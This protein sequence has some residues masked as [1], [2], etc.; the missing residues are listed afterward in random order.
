MRLPISCCWLQSDFVF[1][2]LSL[3][4]IRATYMIRALLVYFLQSQ[5]SCAYRYW[6]ALSPF[7]FEKIIITFLPLIFQKHYLGEN[8]NATPIFRAVYNFIPNLRFLALHCWSRNVRLYGLHFPPG[9]II[10]RCLK[11]M[12]VLRHLSHCSYLR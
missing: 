3:T 2:L 8:N 6:F 11:A 12:S 5:L 1:E 10:Y 9:S 4:F 7:S